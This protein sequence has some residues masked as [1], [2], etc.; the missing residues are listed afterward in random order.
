MRK[1][2]QANQMPF[3]FLESQNFSQR[4]VRSDFDKGNPAYNPLLFEGSFSHIY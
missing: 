4:K 3:N 2:K 1:C